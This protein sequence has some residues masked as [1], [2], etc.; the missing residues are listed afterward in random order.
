MWFRSLSLFGF[1]GS[2]ILLCISSNHCFFFFLWV[3]PSSHIV[4]LSPLLPSLPFRKMEEWLH[5]FQLCPG[6]LP[7]SGTACASNTSD[8]VVTAL[9]ATPVPRCNIEHWD[10]RGAVPCCLDDFLR[11]VLESLKK[12]NFSANKSTRDHDYTSNTCIPARVRPR[13]PKWCFASLSWFSSDD[14]LEVSV[15]C[16]SRVKVVEFPLKHLNSRLCRWDTSHLSMFADYSG[17]RSASALRSFK[18]S[19]N[20]GVGYVIG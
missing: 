13:P 11:N 1:W 14:V 18:L 9:D 6:F 2:I 17:W 7:Q 8:R 12:G 16:D 19:S 3:L 15:A 10:S 20:W 4:L 5:Y